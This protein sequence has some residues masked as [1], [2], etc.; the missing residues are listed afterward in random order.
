MQIFLID[1][2]INYIITIV[3]SKKA[4]WS[5]SL[6]EFKLQ[7]LRACCSPWATATYAQYDHSFFMVVLCQK[8]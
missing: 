5:E 2:N 4:L 8:A 1:G 6:K 3:I 7:D